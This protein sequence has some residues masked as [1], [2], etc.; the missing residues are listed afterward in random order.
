MMLGQPCARCGRRLCAVA[1]RFVNLRVRVRACGFG[2]LPLQSHACLHHAAP[3]MHTPAGTRVPQRLERDQQCEG[4]SRLLLAGR[5]L[6][7]TAARRRT[8]RV[9]RKNSTS[10]SRSRLYHPTERPTRAWGRHGNSSRP[11]CLQLPASRPEWGCPAGQLLWLASALE[12]SIFCES[13]RSTG[14]A[15]H[16]PPSEGRMQ[17]VHAKGGDPP[18][19]TMMQRVTAFMNRIP[20]VVVSLGGSGRLRARL[21]RAV[22]RRPPEGR[23][24]PAHTGRQTTRAHAH[25]W[26]WLCSGRA[27]QGAGAFDSIP[28]PFP[29]LKDRRS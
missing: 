2:R 21:V 26:A 22:H 10:S 12:Q 3:A 27:G 15:P 1:Q 5:Q 6:R 29:A 20:V 8:S 14:S 16:S 18:P 24:A 23:S 4:P 19:Q 25:G 9:P 28:L 13:D 11:P 7:G 17:T